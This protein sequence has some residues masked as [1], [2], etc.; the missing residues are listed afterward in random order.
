[1]PSAHLSIQTG[2]QG[3]AC[4]YLGSD[5][6]GLQSIAMAAQVI[7]GGVASAMVAGGAFFPFQ[8]VHLSWQQRRGLWTDRGEAGLR[9]YAANCDGSLPGEAGALVY[10]EERS[11]A[12]AR[13]AT[14]LGEVIGSAQR[15]TPSGDEDPVGVRAETLRAALPGACPDWVA[16]SAL[17]HAEMD[18]QEAEAY[19]QA[20]GAGLEAAGAVT[21]TPQV[22]FCGPAAAPL[23]LIGAL[24]AARGEVVPHRTLVDA[25]A[26]CES[27]GAAL[28]RHGK[29]GRDSV[30]LA[31]SF[32][33]DGV[34]SALALR[35][36]A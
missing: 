2:Y 4:T 33:L 25:G 8:E 36:E 31:S 32:S 28:G 10:L 23:N 27:L 9:P 6:S 14:I 11:A 30:V 1:M 15:F 34:H 13:G 24:L 29:T 3:P 17:G 19:D 12:E 16:P 35:V 5:S 20:F 21:L 18:R 22:G 7:R 26:G